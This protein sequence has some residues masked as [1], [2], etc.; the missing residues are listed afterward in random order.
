MRRGFKKDIARP[1]QLSLY[2]PHGLATGY[3]GVNST[4]LM[5]ER[6]K[7]RGQLIDARSD[8]GMRHVPDQFQQLLEKIDPQTFMFVATQA[9]HSN[10]NKPD[11]AYWLC[12]LAAK[13]VC[14]EN[15]VV[16][17]AMTAA[18]IIALGFDPIQ[19]ALF[20]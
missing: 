3:D 6:R 15:A 11:L 1:F 10:F 2:A 17:Q 5:S 4:L 16:T 7:R 12:Y 19:Q 8:L 9:D 13:I 18:N 20:F 14:I